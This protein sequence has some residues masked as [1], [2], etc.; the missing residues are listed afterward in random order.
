MKISGY[1]KVGRYLLIGFMLLMTIGILGCSN[2]DQ[3]QVTQSSPAA[4]PEITAEDKAKIEAE[5]KAK[6]EAEAKA[7]AELQAKKDAEAKA[8]AE[9]EAKAQVEKEA[10]EKE[11]LEKTMY[12]DHAILTIADF[13]DNTLELS[14]K[15]YD[16]MVNNHKLFPAL[17]DSDINTAKSMVDKSINAKLLNK[18]PEPYFDKM[19]SF[20]GHV[21][22]IEETQL[23]DKTTI[24]SVHVMDEN[25]Q[26]FEVLLYKE[27][28]D[29]LEDD[30]VT[31]WGTP[32][33]LWSFENISGGFTNSQ[34]FIGSHI[35]KIK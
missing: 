22:D 21:I 24:A 23:E 18:N 6:A 2:K 7:A 4:T 9:A 31:F 34:F 35:E 29:I 17:T 30:R 15:T 25:K 16:F 33:G 20:S 12:A 5:A 10:K 28:G 26:S 1:N 8:K 13:T 19:A 27:T 3:A 14:Q 32:V 11:T